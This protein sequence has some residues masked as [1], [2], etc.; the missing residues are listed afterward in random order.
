MRGGSS[1]RVHGG[2][3]ATGSSSSALRALL[4]LA[5]ACRGHLLRERSPQGV[6]RVEGSV[7]AVDGHFPLLLVRSRREV[8]YERVQGV[9][10]GAAVPSVHRRTRGCVGNP[11]RWGHGVKI[12]ELLQS[13]QVGRDEVPFM[14]FAELGRG[15][16]ARPWVRLGQ[17]YKGFAEHGGEGAVVVG[18][19]YRWGTRKDAGVPVDRLGHVEGANSSLYVVTLS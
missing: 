10:A 7:L 3:T 19:G 15:H 13:P 17:G 6:G 2:A 9:V 18:V 1:P 14:P 4:E 16:R 8:H 12:L 11:R 5:F